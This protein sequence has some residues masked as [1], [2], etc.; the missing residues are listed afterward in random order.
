MLCACVD[1]TDDWESLSSWPEAK[2][3]FEL[4]SFDVFGTI[5]EQLRTSVCNSESA[6]SPV[7]R[8]RTSVCNSES[9]NSPVCNSESANSPVTRTSHVRPI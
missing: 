4:D 5:Q 6:N 1:S 8:T 3:I 7:P 2:N 9:A